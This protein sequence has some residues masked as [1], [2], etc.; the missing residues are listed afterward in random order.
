MAGLRYGALRCRAAARIRTALDKTIVSQ[1]RRAT[2]TCARLDYI[3]T[4]AF[5]MLQDHLK[6]G[7]LLGLVA[8]EHIYVEG[9]PGCGKTLAAE[10]GASA[11]GLSSYFYQ[12]HRDTRVSEL[13]GDAVIHRSLIPGSGCD[14][15]ESAARS[16]VLRLKNVPG[17]VL[18]AQVCILDDITRAPGE[19]LNVLL[20][21]LAERKFGSEQLPLVSAIA[22]A[23]PPGEQYYVDPMDP[24]TLDRFAV[25]LRVKGLV[26]QHDWPSVDAVIKAPNHAWEAPTTGTDKSQLVTELEAAQAEAAS[27]NILPRVQRLLLRLMQVLWDMPGVGGDKHALSDRAFLVKSLKLMQ[28]QAHVMGRQATYPDDLHVLALM[29]TFRVPPE[30]SPTTSCRPASCASC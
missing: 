14:A 30:V 18:T 5:H 2:N 17:G 23:N 29:T 9:P 28:A 20:R 6:H 11:S 16:E 19:A 4:L 8:R 27:V 7:V 12:L 25:Q 15:L 1:V 21:V 22:T 24:A 3:L 10:L 13:V 26:G